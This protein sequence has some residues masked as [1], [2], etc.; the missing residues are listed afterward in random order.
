MTQKA[1]RNVIIKICALVALTV[2]IPAFAASTDNAHSL[3]RYQTAGVVEK[4]TPGLRQA[5]IDTDAIPGYMA[6]M[7]MDYPVLDTNEMHGISPGDRIS[8]VLV[9][10]QTNDW[11]ENV[12][13]TSHSA[14][15]NQAPAHAD[16]S[17]GAVIGELKTGDELPNGTLIAEDGQRIQFSKYRGEAVAFTFFYTRCPLPNYCPLMNRN[18]A[19]ARNLILSGKDA[20]TNWE[21]LSI[22]FDPQ[23]DT[24]EALSNYAQAFRGDNTN[25]WAFAAATKKS[26]GV[27]APALDLMVIH[28]GDAISHNLRTVVMDPQGRIARQ[29]DGNQWTARELADAVVQAA[30]TRGD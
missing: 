12:H 24:P 15:T 27:L 26:L 29:F 20:P 13:C 2:A 14:V 21:F 11:I 3:T 22:S 4:I 18:F 19:A 9:I 10:S 30:R 25:H 1:I 16:N 8:F 23:D 6:H 5:T 7:T 17:T 28:H